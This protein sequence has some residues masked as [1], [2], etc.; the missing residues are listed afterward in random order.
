MVYLLSKRIDHLGNYGCHFY[1]ELIVSRC[2]CGL[3]KK[4]SK[5]AVSIILNQPTFTIDFESVPTSFPHL[6]SILGFC[7][8]TFTVNILRYILHLI[9]LKARE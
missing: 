7:H 5:N 4:I 6:Q 1:Q 2:K 3:T 8:F 9:V